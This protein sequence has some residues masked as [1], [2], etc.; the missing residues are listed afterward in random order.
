M[1]KLLRRISRLLKLTLG[2]NRFEIEIIVDKKLFNA[3][4]VEL[5]VAHTYSTCKY[6]VVPFHRSTIQEITFYEDDAVIKIK[7]R[8]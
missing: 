4:Y 6:K 1:E 7:K 8:N 2:V 3:I 5:V